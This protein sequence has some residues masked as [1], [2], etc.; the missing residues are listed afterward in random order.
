MEIITQFFT[1]SIVI[2]NMSMLLAVLV[3]FGLAYLFNHKYNDGSSKVFLYLARIA[4][5]LAAVVLIIWF[6]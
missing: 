3:L 2:K 4:I 1:N 5:I 6:F